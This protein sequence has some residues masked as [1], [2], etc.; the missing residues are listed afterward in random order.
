M[1]LPPNEEDE[2]L[3]L[4]GKRPPKLAR[5]EAA[6]LEHWNEENEAWQYTPGRFWPPG[7]GPY[8]REESEPAEGGGDGSEASRHDSNLAEGGAKKTEHAANARVA[9]QKSERR[10]RRL[11]PQS[12]GGRAAP[13]PRNRNGRPDTEGVT[14]RSGPVPIRLSD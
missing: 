11:N 14:A 5:K 4:A 10:R 7:Y 3:I 6:R 12:N 1:P 13:G 8:G 9:T 2:K